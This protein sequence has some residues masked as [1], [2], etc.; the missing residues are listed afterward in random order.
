[1]RA[2]RRIARGHALWA[3]VLILLTLAVRIIVPPGYMPALDHG[4]VV[5]EPCSGHGVMT[6]PMGDMAGMADH[7]SG[8]HAMTAKQDMPCGFGLLAIGCTGGADVALLAVAIAFILARAW[9]L[10]YPPRLAPR[11]RLRPPLRAPPGAFL[12]A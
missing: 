7:M 8:K 1:M 2:L 4:R 10:P 5:M 3:A 12:L 11:S 6:M 9:R